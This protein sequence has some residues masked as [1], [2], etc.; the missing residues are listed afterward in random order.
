MEKMVL[1]GNAVGGPFQQVEPLLTVGDG[2][3]VQTDGAVAGQLPGAGMENFAGVAVQNLIGDALGFK[4]I[5]G[6]TGRYVRQTMNYLN[7][8]YQ[9]NVQLSDVAAKVG[10]PPAISARFSEIM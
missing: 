10:C 5:I 6:G 7:R 2:K 9:E 4:G 8:H 1:A 3:A